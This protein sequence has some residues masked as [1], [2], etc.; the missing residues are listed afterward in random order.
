ML[1]SKR[2]SA[3]FLVVAVMASILATAL[4]AWAAPA[5]T[6]TRTS[7]AAI[8][9][10][11]GQSA[12]IRVT[13]NS[14]G[15][16][17]GLPALGER[18]NAVQIILPTGTTG[19][20]NNLAV[21]APTPANWTVQR[22]SAG[23]L[24]TLAFKANDGDAAIA[25]SANLTFNIP[26]NVAQ[27][28]NSDRA[29]NYQIQVSSDGGQTSAGV[30][31]AT[32]VLNTV[33]RVLEITDVA[34]TSPAGAADGSGTAGQAIQMGVTL[35]N[36]AA[37]AI[38]VDPSLTSNNGTDEITDNNSATTLAASGGTTTVPFPVTLGG[39]SGSDRTAQFTGDGTG[40]SIDG[41]HKQ[42]AY[43][44]QV[45]PNLNLTADSFS[46]KAVR[47]HPT[48]QY[49]FTI[50][51]SKAGTP[52]LDL[53]SGNFDFANEDAALQLPV[54]YADNGST[55]TLSFG[56]ITVSTDNVDDV[57]DGIFTFAGTDAN[58]KAFS[59]EITLTDLITVDGIA[60]IITAV[61]DLPNDAEGDA[62]TAAKNGN[63]IDVSG[64]V[65]DSSATIDMVQIQDNAGG[66]FDVP[67]TRTGNN[68][69]GSRAVTFNPG[70]SEFWVYAKATDAAGNPG[71]V[72]STQ[73][74]VDNDI[75][76][77]VEA[78]LLGARSVSVRFDDGLNSDG[79]ERRVK[80]GCNVSQ[81]R[82]QGNIVSAVSYS[83]GTPC[84]D[85]QAGPDNYRFLTLS[86]SED[87]DSEK[88]VTYTPVPLLR[89]QAKDGAGNFTP[90]TVLDWVS[91]I[92][93]D[94]PTIQAVKRNA[95]A[96]TATF[97]EDKYWT[98]FGGDDL[99]V[100]FAGGR[101]NYTVIVRDGNGNILR[102]EPM[103]TTT[104]TVGVPIG[105]AEGT[106]TRSLQL[107]GTNNLLSDLTTFQVQ[108]DRTAPLIQNAV[109]ALSGDVEVTFTEILP[110]GT[111]FSFDWYGY[112]QDA[113]GE[114][115]YYAV[116]QVTGTGN[117]RTLSGID[118]A[119]VAPFGGV[120]YVFGGGGSR[121]RDRAGNEFGDTTVFDGS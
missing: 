89:D 98:R 110:E 106:Y 69:S 113:D 39:A 33:V 114:R 26:I 27:P 19:I 25:S 47:P 64:S 56:P 41:V 66:T 101:A 71:E 9:P 17:L 102:E 111:N 115:F 121:Y 61:A 59:Q 95:G 15:G 31:T 100:D 34:A 62:Q 80:G 50:N 85:S 112:E 119:D 54:G 55:A 58:G 75:P 42:V 97:D 21:P 99:T 12:A 44:V 107:R 24:Q 90:E 92:A 70:A 91:A 68:Y 72:N 32:S 88:P 94:A 117:Q 7:S 57:Y 53:S 73:L 83:D 79:T 78:T 3:L 13:N 20:S 67:V 28:A 38:T 96:E 43:V 45:A 52:D 29:G 35:K 30:T 74:G 116:D 49:T 93:P 8:F 118:W 65:D 105:T 5:A 40:N 10:G 120:D 82:V 108:L 37:N 22:I 77:A 87:Q 1:R 23:N 4:P 36:H 109:K 48:I 60:P 51:S 18:I 11:Q 81:W 63:T 104:G 6:A 84:Q 103:S 86:Q 16:P 2:L 14:V 76:A 46:P